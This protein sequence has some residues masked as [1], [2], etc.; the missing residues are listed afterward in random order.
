MA[1]GQSVPTV[2]NLPN[3]APQ[4]SATTGKAGDLFSITDSQGNKATIT[5]ESATTDQPGQY[6]YA[7]ARGRYVE[8]VV[9]AT[10]RSGS[11]SVNPYDFKLVGPDGTSYDHSY[12]SDSKVPRLDAK[13]LSSGGRSRGSIIFDAPK[14]ALTLQ[15]C[16]LFGSAVARWQ[17]A[18]G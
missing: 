3:S 1:T 9:A 17:V 4:G 16:P 18:A 10:G 12:V 14:T 13:S 2:P 7:A 5:M 6:D 8:V 11:T 15:Y